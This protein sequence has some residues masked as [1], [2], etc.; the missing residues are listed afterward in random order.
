MSERGS[1]TVEHAA[2]AALIA[3]LLIAA[4]SALA[5]NPRTKAGRELAGAIGRKLACAP[6]LPDPCHRNPLAWAYGF[7]VGK[8][9]RWLAPA[10]GVAGGLV[11]VDFR[12]CRS[13]SCARADD[14]R[15]TTSGRLITEFTV[16]EDLRRTTG[17]V[18][19][20]YWM[21]RPGQPWQKV[22][23][24]GGAGEIEAASSLRLRVTDTPALVPLETVLGRDQY[25]FPAAE[26]PP[27]RWRVPG[28]YK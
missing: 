26:E 20:T 3:L 24:S 12:R 17:L 8:L 14:A 1:A 11:P 13:D 23:Q 4:I 7:P 27:W 10:A 25:D 9:V 15:L 21:Y 22:V 5:S 18:R 6:R 16:V 28:I 2:L 19:V